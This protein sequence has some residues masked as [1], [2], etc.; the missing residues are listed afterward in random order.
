[1]LASLVL[2]P[3]TESNA[4]GYYA[5]RVLGSIAILLAVYAVSFRRTLVIAALL[6]AIPATV[7]HLLDVRADGF[8]PILNIV[9]SFLFDVFVV[10]V[11]FRKVFAPRQPDSETIFG[12]L[13]IYM[14]VGFTFA[15]VYGLIA[16][17][18]AQ[19]FYLDPTV[20]LHR[21]PNRLD[22]IYYS[23]GTL[24]SL[25]ASGIVP[26]TGPA[27]SITVIEAI[28]GVLYLAVLISRLVGAYRHPT[29]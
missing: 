15:S 23:F 26:V 16:R 4:F 6:L 14:L 29:G 27:R 28:L 2:Y 7:Q 25:G 24:T 1:M 5:F 13:C 17:T 8:L 20:N 9:L 18:E 11:I 22:F 12:A 10:V 21:V 19:A 3:Y